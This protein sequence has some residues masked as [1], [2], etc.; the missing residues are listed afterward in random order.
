MI[1]LKDILNES[2]IIQGKVYTDKDLKPFKV[3]EEGDYCPD[4]EEM[5]E[6][7]MGTV[8]PPKYSSPEAKKV[9]D[10]AL[11]NYSKDLRKLQYRVVKDW[12]SKAKA[13]TIDFFDLV[14]GFQSGDISRAYPY[15]VKFLQSVLTRD[16]IIDRFRKYFGGKKGKYIR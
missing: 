12:M 14:R 13:G 8:A 4:D 3:N 16:K 6:G 5:E 1:K 11:K 9:V 15:E 2:K 7:H 10:G